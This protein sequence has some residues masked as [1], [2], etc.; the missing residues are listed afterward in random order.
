[1]RKCSA[2]GKNIGEKGKGNLCKIHYNRQKQYGNPYIH[3]MKQPNG[4]L[5]VLVDDRLQP[6]QTE[7]TRQGTAFAKEDIDTVTA[8][9]IRQGKRVKVMFL[10]RLPKQYDV[11]E[12]L[13]KTRFDLTKDEGDRFG[14]VDFDGNLVNMASDRYKCFSLHGTTCMTCGL[15]GRYFYLEKTQIEAK[16]YHFNLYGVNDHGEEI[17][18]TKDHIIPK[19]KGGS[20]SIDNYQTMCKPC[21]EMKGN[22]L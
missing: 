18:V 2:C 1:M 9:Q 20:D 8:D 4:N 5:H 7:Q 21:N 16:R 17:L 3:F 14:M 15:K 12:V 22:D 6:G 13:S 19:S 11:H 10:D